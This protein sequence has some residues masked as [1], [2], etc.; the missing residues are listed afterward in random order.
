MQALPPSG[1]ALAAMRARRVRKPGKRAALR[2]SA[3][4]DWA[5]AQRAEGRSAG[6]ARLPDLRVR[7]PL[8][9]MRCAAGQRPAG[10]DQKPGA[11][12]VRPAPLGLLAR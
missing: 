5:D 3:R 7:A 9:A 10:V 11:G 8:H 2:A 4:G 1:G 6:Q 12:A